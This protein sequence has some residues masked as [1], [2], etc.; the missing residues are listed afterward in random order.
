MSAILLNSPFLE[1]KTS[2]QDHADNLTPEWA[3]ARAIHGTCNYNTKVGGKL[4]V[5][6]CVVDLTV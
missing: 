4:Q 2:Q 3:G 6:P 1:L 5:K